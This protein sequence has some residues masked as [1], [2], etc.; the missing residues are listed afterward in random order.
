M[1]SIRLLVVRGSYPKSSFLTAPN[2]RMQAHPPG[3]GLPRHDPSVTR[4]AFFIAVGVK[5]AGEAGLPVQLNRSL[6][7]EMVFRTQRQGG[8]GNPEASVV[9]KTPQEGSTARAS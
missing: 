7:P 3:P 6:E 9:P 8:A 1:S 2:R 4:E 5:V